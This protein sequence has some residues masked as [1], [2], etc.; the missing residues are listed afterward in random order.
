MHLGS[1]HFSVIFP[2]ANCNLWN[3][4]QGNWGCFKSEKIVSFISL[5]IHEAFGGS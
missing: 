5:R 2:G 3:L 1:A 4:V